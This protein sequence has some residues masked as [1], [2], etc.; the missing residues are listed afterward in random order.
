MGRSLTW[1][2]FRVVGRYFA[3]QRLF[4]C[5]DSLQLPFK[6]FF[7]SFIFLYHFIE[8]AFVSLIINIFNSLTLNQCLC[9]IDLQ[10]VSDAYYLPKSLIK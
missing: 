2:I 7:H 5:C 10:S 1:D 4:L 9:V 8:S 6:H 3:D